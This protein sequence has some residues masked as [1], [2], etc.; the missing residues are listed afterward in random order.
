MLAYL[1]VIFAIAFRFVQHGPLVAWCQS[2]GLWNFTP[3]GASLL[4]F[5]AR[6]PLRRLW[7]PV[8]A[9]AGSDL[10]LTRFVYHSQFTLTA[11][12]V[13]AWYA[14]A[15]L[16]GGSLR[17]RTL[18]RSRIDCMRFAGAALA[19]PVSFFLISNFSVWLSDGLY[20]HTFA[21]LAT[22]YTVAI[23]FFRNTFVGDLLWAAVLF[24]LPL[25]FEAVNRRKAQQIA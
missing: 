24:G 3:V 4:Y 10:L 2:C 8:A 1:Y 13:V 14:V 17:R 20:P 25:A 12:I 6:Q 15:V 16:L 18:L 11:A 5:G 7:I 19:I 9:L 23:P 22:C 21:G